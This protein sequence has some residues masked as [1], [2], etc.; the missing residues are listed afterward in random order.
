[1]KAGGE[2]D[3][4]GWDGWMASP[5]RSHEFEQALTV[6]DDREAWCAAVHGVAKI[7][8]WLSNWTDK[9]NWFIIIFAS[10]FPYEH[11]HT[12]IYIHKHTPLNQATKIVIIIY[13]HV[14]ITDTHRK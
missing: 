3:D 14:G 8:T 5:T 9:W 7:W 4:R 2:G 6:G 12:H 1:M 11:T 10:Y 13:I